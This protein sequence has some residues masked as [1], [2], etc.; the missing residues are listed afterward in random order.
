[1]IQRPSSQGSS[2]LIDGRL[3][4]MV[5]PSTSLLM[6]R[7]PSLMVLTVGTPDYTATTDS[8]SNSA[9]FYT[10]QTSTTAAYNAVHLWHG[11]ATV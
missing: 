11:W 8:K 2:S 10:Q 9:G 5:K 7:R 1:M 6:D 4:P 3:E